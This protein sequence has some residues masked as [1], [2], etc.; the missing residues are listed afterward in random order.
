MRADRGGHVAGGFDRE[1]TLFCERK[2]RFSGFLRYQGQVDLFS[3]EGPL[4]GAAE[5]EQCFGEVDRPGVDGMEAVDKL[6]IDSVRI[7]AGDVEKRLRD[8]QRGAQFVGGVGGESLLFG[9]VRF[10]PREDRRRRRRR[11]RGTHP[12]GPGAR[13]FRWRSSDLVAAV[14]CGVGDAGAGP[15]AS[16][17]PSEIETT[18]MIASEIR[19][20]RASGDVGTTAAALGANLACRQRWTGRE[21]SHEGC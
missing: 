4:V 14:A 16:R 3:G 5:Q 18:V 2:E 10:E 7:V 6:A 13:E 11:A 9:D 17:R 12:G 8:R 1:A 21:D 15:G 19:T 20:G